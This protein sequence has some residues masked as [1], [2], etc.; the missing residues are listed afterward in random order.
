M[1]LNLCIMIDGRGRLKLKRLNN[2]VQM[3]NLISKK[4]LW[5]IK[6]VSSNKILI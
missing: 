3:K 6:E 5:I 4:E 1:K 2:L